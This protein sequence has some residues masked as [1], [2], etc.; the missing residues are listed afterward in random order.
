MVRQAVALIAAVMLTGMDAA[1]TVPPPIL[2]LLGDV[3]AAQSFDYYGLKAAGADLDGLNAAV[4]ARLRPE[5]G[6]RCI[7]QAEQT[8]LAGLKTAADAP[9]AAVWASDRD[10]ADRALERWRALRDSVL[11]GGKA[12]PPY[13]T[14]GEQ[15]AALSAVREPRKRAL[16]ERAALDQF[17]RASWV[18]A[19]DAWLGPLSEGA[20][21]RVNRTFAGEGCRVDADNAAWLE[22][23]L[24]T[25]GWFRRSIYGEDG[26]AAAWLIVQHAD[27]DLA[28][29][30]RVLALLESLI[31]DGETDA[32]NYAYLHDRTAV[33]DG[34]SQR[35][36]TQGGCTAPG[37]WSPRPMEDPAGVDARRRQMGLEPLDTERP[38]LNARCARFPD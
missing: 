5:L 13:E 31:A 8:V 32:A 19:G 27:R 7:T 24:A 33:N 11:S 29:Q 20:R 23:E 34:R 14:V 2:S 3:E 4:E 30:Q 12:P 1:P 15:V 26:D 9:T 28:F 38:R 22:R 17:M 18:E 16:L 21:T 25:H 10:D 6:S 36:G 35:Y 37:Q